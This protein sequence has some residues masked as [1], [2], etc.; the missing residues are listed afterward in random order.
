MAFAAHAP[1]IRPAYG[2]VIHQAVAAHPAL[3]GAEESQ[4]SDFQAGFPA[5]VPLVVLA[6]LAGL[7]TD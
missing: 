2:R 5:A 4:A 7:R 6:G 1:A 3:A